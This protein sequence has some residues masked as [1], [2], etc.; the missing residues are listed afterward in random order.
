MLRNLAIAFAVILALAGGVYLVAR[1]LGGDH[2]STG[3]A[4]GTVPTAADSGARRVQQALAELQAIAEGSQRLM[5]EGFEQLF[6]SMP[7]ADLRRLRPRIRRDTSP[8]GN[9]N[10]GQEVWEED[11][12][13]G[14]RVV[15]LVSSRAQLLN[16][17]QFA[18]RLT[19]AP[20]L[21]AHMQAMTARYGTPTGIWDCP[22]T[23]ESSPLRRFTWRRPGASV[24]DVV[25]IYGN[26]IALTLVIAA[27]DDV[28]R[29]LARSQCQPVRSPEAIANFPVARDLRG[30]RTQIVR[31][32]PP[33]APRAGTAPQPP[34]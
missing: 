29:A 30:E 7:L 2:A 25:L 28:A 21:T 10:D 26:T 23:P 14:A 31:E 5:P 9:R 6:V 27:T 34:R 1:R 8:A 24:M 17:V 33:P 20:E 18:S 19:S 11:D 13:S 22:E 3:A 12:A 4:E 32:I 15:Y 16:Q